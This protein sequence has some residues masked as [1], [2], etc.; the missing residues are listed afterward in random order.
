[1][2][3]QVKGNNRRDKRYLYN[4]GIS[5]SF[6]DRKLTSS[7]RINF[8]EG[9]TSEL[10]M[11]TMQDTTRLLTQYNQQKR[12]R[13]GLR[14]N[15]QLKR[16]TLSLNVERIIYRNSHFTEFNYRELLARFTFYV[17]FGSKEI[18]YNPMNR[19]LRY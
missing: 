2:R 18:A 19:A 15:Y 11:L 1:M 5:S 12:F 17:H 14:C 3:T 13:L 4:A 7:L 6:F 9:K 16:T 10:F 8:D